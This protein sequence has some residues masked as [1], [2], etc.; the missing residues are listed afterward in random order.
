MKYL[1]MEKHQGYVILLDEEGSF[2]RAVDRGYEVGQTLTEPMILAPVQAKRQP[3]SILKQFT[4]FA[5]TAVLLFAIGFGIW[6]QNFAVFTTVHI[7]INPDLRMDLSH[8]GNILK[9]VA[10][11]EDASALLAGYESK[12]K[13]RRTVTA[14]LIERAI[15]QG[16]LEEGDRILLDIESRHEHDRTEYEEEFAAR[17]AHAL[18]DMKVSIAVVGIQGL[19][20][21]TEGTEPAPNTTSPPVTD[22]ADTG[23]GDTDPADS[24]P[25]DTDPPR[26]LTGE[27][28][29]AI[30][31]EHAGLTQSKINELETE[32][33]TDDGP[34]HYEIEFIHGGYEYEYKIDVK[35]GRILESK[36]EAI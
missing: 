14:E 22:P 33:V 28:A 16:Y 1:V 7:T 29:L 10:L 25:A 4:A 9:L 36:K 20:S 17:I 26:D 21:D 5:L 24:R 31:L 35:E 6:Q 3:R 18:G 23:T 8:A 19:P 13:D 12:G 2:L 15:A 11:N 34:I 32:Y 30:A 27:E